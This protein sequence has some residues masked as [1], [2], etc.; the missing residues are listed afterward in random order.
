MYSNIR[1][2][3]EFSTKEDIEQNNGLCVLSNT[4]RC[5]ATARVNGEFY[6]ELEYPL[7]IDNKSQYLRIGNII[8]CET[9]AGLELFRIK[10]IDKTNHTKI[11][12]IAEHILFDLDNFFLEDVRPTEVTG[13]QALD[14]IFN[15]AINDKDEENPYDCYSDITNISTAN[16]VRKN[17]IESLIELD[18][19]FIER[20]GGEVVYNRFTLK[21][22]E[23]AGFDRGFE[24]RFN[25]NLT[26]IQ[27]NESTSKQEVITKIMPTGLTKDNTTLIL[28]EKYIVSERV[29]NY[30][31]GK[32][33]EIHYSDLKEVIDSENEEENISRE[34][35]Y[36]LLRERALQ[37]FEINKIDLPYSSINIK[38]ALLRNIENYKNS[39]YEMLEEVSLYDT[40]TLIDEDL[41]INLKS[42]IILTKYDCLK[43]Q[44]IEV[45]CGSFKKDFISSSVSSSQVKEEIKQNNTSI[46]NQAIKDANDWLTGDN[47]KKGYLKIRKTEDGGIKDILIMNAKTEELSTEAI[48]LN[49]SGLGGIT[50]EIGQPIEGFI[51]ASI[52]TNGVINA[53]LIRSGYMIADRIKSGVLS[54]IDETVEINLDD[55]GIKLKDKN[56]AKSVDIRD[57]AIYFYDWINDKEAGYLGATQNTKDNNIRTFTIASALNKPFYIGCT[58]KVS[59]N[60]Y[61][62]FK[63]VAEINI[64]NTFPFQ[65]LT[66]TSLA[67]GCL[68]IKDKGTG[69]ADFKAFGDWDYN[70]WSLRNIGNLSV[71][72]SKNCS[73]KTENFGNRLI[74]AYET[75]EYFFGDIG[76]GTIGKEGCC[77][78][79]IDE[80]LLECIN[81]DL[82][83]H[84]FTSVYHGSITKIDRFKDYFVIHGTEGTEFT[85]ELKAKRRGFEKHRL[86]LDKI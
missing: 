4:L 63:T 13:L 54:S 46:L 35:I 80:I 23:E 77:Y 42:K 68:E 52:Q 53:S 39:K 81:T 22:L 11:S 58:S 28:P 25:K 26:S 57:N 51:K 78:I 56:G 2:Y 40:I 71:S 37:E 32:T 70:N 55:G 18:N 65:T 17:V 82:K 85:W 9:Q 15:N 75:A 83:Y 1:V 43:Q 10:D 8:E 44:Y 62:E 31:F 72:G 45:E 21:I 50:K 41:N 73:Q 47:N 6:I 33:K 34:E 76:E 59:E 79:Y 36:E 27:T 74:N 64:K 84:V 60:G 19:C 86:E 69:S 3:D 66:S 49:S 30:R 20:W 61:H 14:H 5:E 38:F 29:G 7:F 67:N 16:Y 48:I 12:L 24:V